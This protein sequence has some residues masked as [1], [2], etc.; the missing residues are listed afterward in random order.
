MNR[1]YKHNQLLNVCDEFLAIYDD[2]FNEASEAKRM[3]QIQ[4]RRTLEGEMCGFLTEIDFF[5]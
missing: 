3:F 5:N 1:E 2:K 4:I